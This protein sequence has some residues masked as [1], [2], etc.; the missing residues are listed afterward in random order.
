[1]KFWYLPAGIT[2]LTA[3][4][5]A[6]AGALTDWLL[7]LA[8]AEQWALYF[9]ARFAAA[10]GVIALALELLLF[11]RLKTIYRILLRFLKR[12]KTNGV[13]S[14]RDVVSGLHHAISDIS[15]SITREFREMKELDLFRKEYIGVVSHELKTPIFVIEGYLET[16]MDGAL[17]DESVN[18]KFISQSLKNVQ[19]LNNL[20]QDLIVIS[21]LESGQ[22]EMKKESFRVYTLI[23][24]V[25]EQTSQI[26]SVNDTKPKLIL[27]TNDNEGVYVLADKDRI[28][29]VVMNLV[30]NAIRYGR[31]EKGFVKVEMRNNDD[32][33]FVSVIDNGIG[34]DQEHLAHIFER[35]YRIEKSRSR[36]QGGTGLGLSIVKNL[37]DAHGEEISVDSKP[38]EGTTFTF[39]LTKD[40]RGAS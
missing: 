33:L 8:G 31:E 36:G 11:K 21:Q 38:G 16:L 14:E 19:R 15:G 25:F 22:M 30:T 4:L 10:A 1:M 6:L 5:V 40:K 12:R 18:R 37:L 23:M 2:V 13:A 7:A 28:R 17:E 3:L 35:F 26:L 32:K 24:D 9:A 39:S 20:V 27:E 29:Q 34:I